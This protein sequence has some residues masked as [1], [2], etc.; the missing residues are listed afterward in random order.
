MDDED[1]R[2]TDIRALK[3]DR[4]NPSPT[5]PGESSDDTIDSSQTEENGLWIVDG[6]VLS[7]PKATESSVIFCSLAVAAAEHAE[8]IRPCLGHS[9]DDSG[10]LARFELF[11]TAFLQGGTFVYVP[12]NTV[13]QEPL[14]IHEVSA[15]D[16]RAN[17]AHVIVIAGRGS[18]VSV[19]REQYSKDSEASTLC[20]DRIDVIAEAGASVSFCNIQNWNQRTWSFSSQRAS[21]AAD[22]NV[23]LIVGEFGSRLRK[24]NQDVSIT[25]S[26]G[27]VDMLGAMVADG[28]QLVSPSTLQSHEAPHTRS[29]LLYRGAV[30]DSARTVWRGNIRVHPQAQK[31]DAYQA[32]HNLVLSGEARADAIPGLEIEADDVRCTHGATM[33]RIDPEQLFYLKCRGIAEPAARRMIIDGFFDPVLE[34]IRSEAAR[35]ILADGI[36]AKLWSSSRTAR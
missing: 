18:E 6:A 16:G 22:S 21:Q 25:G 30:L 33:G 4:Y 9:G 20:A 3:L 2:R 8:L 24:T 10:S 13:V 28:T 5:H 15:Q 31:T 26:G 7:E 27:N 34:R 29:D 1:W 35:D 12:P 19:I 32:Q 36:A 14:R 17:T 23:Q 11:A